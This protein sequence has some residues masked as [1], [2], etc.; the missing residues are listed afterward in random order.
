VGKAL[1]HLEAE[2]K[3]EEEDD[4]ASTAPAVEAATSS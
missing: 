3:K 4:G 2:L 1:E